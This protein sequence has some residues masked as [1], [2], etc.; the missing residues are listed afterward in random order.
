MN[1]FTVGATGAIGRPL[2][3]RLLSEGHKVSAL[4][5]SEEKASS[6]RQLGVT[7][8]VGNILDRHNVL[9][10]I[11]SSHPDVVIN[12]LTSLPKQYTP[13]EMKAAAAR[14]DPLR[15][16]AG[17]N[18]LFAMQQV[19]T[20]RY[21]M[22]SAAFLYEEGEGL[23]DETTSFALQASPGIQHTAHV[24]QQLENQVL[25]GNGIEGVILR[26]GF[27]YGPGTWYAPDGSVADQV[28][29]Q[30]FPIIADG[31]GLWSFVHIED[32]AQAI[33]EAVK[34]P[35]GIYN[36]TDD[37]P[38]SMAAWL[39]AF[40]QW[41]KAPAPLHISAAEC[42]SVDRLYYATRLRGASNAK[43]KRELKFRS[44]PLMW[45]SS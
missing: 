9:E 2:L 7:P 45:I 23:A 28:C 41:L 32:A 39:P 3:N 25:L 42:P 24:Y 11:R 13:E 18:L 34:G 20:R 16:A 1:I 22:Q 37:Q 30:Q 17:E 36:I 31:K 27:F 33:Q 21:L 5:Q 12:M 4:A 19:G 10:C 29:K 26:F 43:A 38:I 44:R 6:L 35:V 15:L 8:Y 40:A 14:N